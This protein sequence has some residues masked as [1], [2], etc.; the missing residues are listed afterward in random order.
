MIIY[1]V[2]SIGALLLAIYVFTHFLSRRIALENDRYYKEK[3]MIFT[4]IAHDLKTPMTTVIGFSK[5]L[6]N[7]EVTDENEKKEMFDSIYQKSMRAN[8]LLDLIFQYTKFDALDFRLN[9]EECDIAKLL[10]KLTAEY[11]NDFEEKHIEIEI[12]IPD[13][14]IWANID[15]V[16]FSRAL[17][18][19]IINA[20]RHNPENAKVMIQLE[21]NSGIKITIADNGEAINDYTIFEPF[22]CGDKSRSTNGGSGL[23]LTI[24][25]KIVELHGGRLY[26]DSGIRGY[27]KGFVVRL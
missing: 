15:K 19:L 23:G 20:Y 27:T 6:C 8:E 12:N 26:V 10:R 22:V 25:K 21:N 14:K 5:A 24:A 7:G 16:E 2:V 4:N 3:S 1:G 17:S 18:N 11:Y 13:T 9:I